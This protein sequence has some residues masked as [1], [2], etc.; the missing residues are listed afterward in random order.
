MKTSSIRLVT[1]TIL[2][3]LLSTAASAQEWTWIMG[4]VDSLTEQTAYEA[5]CKRI[6][7]Y[8][9][10]RGL[11]SGA[12]VKES[13]L[14]HRPA[15]DVVYLG[16]LH[17]FSNRDWLAPHFPDS[18]DLP[19]RFHGK[20]L[21]SSN[22]G[23]YLRSGDGRTVYYTGLSMTGFEFIF[24]KPT[25]SHDC[26]ILVD[27]EVRFEGDYRGDDLILKSLPFMPTYPRVEDLSSLVQL[28]GAIETSPFYEEATSGELSQRSIDSIAEL[29]RDQRV[30]FVGESHWNVGVNQVFH[31][32]L[33]NLLKGK[34]VR[35]V[36]FEFNY[37]FSGHWNHYVHLSDDAEALAFREGPLHNLVNT[38]S[39]LACLELIRQWNL[40][41]SESQVD[42]GCIDM[43]WSHDAV[44]Q[45][46][47]RPY[48]RHFD[49]E[50]EPGSM[51]R[52]PLMR[53]I[54]EIGK[55]LSILEEEEADGPYA[56]QTPGYMQS[57]LTNLKDTLA[58]EERPVDRQRGI[59]RNL[60][61]FHADLL[62]DGLIV[63]KGGGWHAV[64]HPQGDEGFWREAAFLHQ[65]F[66]ETRGKVKTLHIQGLGI[67]FDEVENLDLGRLLPHATNY[68]NFV[69]GFQR[70]VLTGRAERGEHYVID[71]SSLT[72]VDRL[73]MRSAYVKDRDAL[74]LQRVDDEELA[75]SGARSDMHP[76]TRYDAVV[77]VLRSQLEPTR[78]RR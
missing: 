40:A 6:F 62:T 64:K 30:L 36:F 37:S 63:F 5:G 39:Q 24:T 35:A 26:T 61:E 50:W 29:V 31:D 51:S 22:T 66:E 76:L 13:A 57:V 77:Y 21:S 56:F 59:L 3:F 46:I 18:E 54:E 17:A 44:V 11:M 2:L 28:D 10:T 75:K 41:N 52:R 60:T 42:V 12:L 67:G 49:P 15:E 34:R 78:E 68:R 23:I 58:I 33:E 71:A 7:D 8:Y 73:V 25:G 55:V 32:V 47:I 65:E 38:E 70:A 14:S 43:E 16:P 1:T 45:N 74:W 69:Q 72:T 27:G 48:M 9:Q 19:L 53:T 20:E 4:K